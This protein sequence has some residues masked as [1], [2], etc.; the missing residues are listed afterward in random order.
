LTNNKKTWYNK[1]KKQKTEKPKMAKKDRQPRV[2]MSFS[3]DEGAYETVKV[4]CDKT[5]Q[6]ISG[7]VDTYLQTMA[8]TIRLTGLDKKKDVTRADLL[9]LALKGIGE[10]P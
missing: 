8:R 5:G 9:R 6:N 10:S 7:L 1:L 2:T 3:V 4:F